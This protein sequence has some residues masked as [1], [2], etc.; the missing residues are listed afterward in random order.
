MDQIISSNNKTEFGPYYINLHNIKTLKE[1]VEN[2]TA[3]FL[4]DSNGKVNTAPIYNANNGVCL[5]N[6]DLLI[7]KEHQKNLE[8]NCDYVGTFKTQE[9]LGLQPAG[10]KVGCSY[11][12]KEADKKVYHDAK[13]YF[14]I[15]FT[16]PDKFTKEAFKV[17]FPPRLTD[18]TFKVENGADYLPAYYAA[19]ESGLN[20][21][22]S[23]KA[24]EEFKTE[25]VS[26]AENNLKRSQ[27]QNPEISASLRDYCIKAD[28]K[29]KDIIKSFNVSKEQKKEQK[30]EK[31]QS[32]T[33]KPKAKK[34]E[35]DQEVVF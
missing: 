14:P 20:I 31:Q 10:K 25:F 1:A 26:I 16:E 12:W 3:S 4:A 34:I 11:V 17:Q 5:G 8:T 30:V 29:A 28:I 18:K 6:I 2:G 15:E 27:N 32:N 23:Q 35:R 9:K 24:L 19:C 7:V 22:V 33:Q 21:E 13:F